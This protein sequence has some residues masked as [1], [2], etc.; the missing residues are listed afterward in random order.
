MKLPPLTVLS[1][2]ASYHPFK[3]TRHSLERASASRTRFQP[4][5]LR[6]VYSD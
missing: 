6:Q 3:E 5:P 1:D 4:R 2:T